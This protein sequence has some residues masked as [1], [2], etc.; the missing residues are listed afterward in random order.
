MKTFKAC[1]QLNG[2]NEKNIYST[3]ERDENGSTVKL[4]L[5]GRFYPGFSWKSCF[6]ILIS[7]VVLLG[8]FLETWPTQ[9]DYYVF[10]VTMVSRNDFCFVFP[11][12]LTLKGP[13]TN[14]DEK[15]VWFPF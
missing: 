3:N 7:D 1:K 15:V 10:I 2:L 11:V 12:K 5:K 8:Y 4:D 13:Y 6:F 14:L 9:V